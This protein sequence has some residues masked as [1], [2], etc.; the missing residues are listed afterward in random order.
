ME[1]IDY[2]VRLGLGVYSAD[3]S[4]S[5]DSMDQAI[6]L[7]PQVERV[8]PLEGKDSEIEPFQFESRQEL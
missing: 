4:H 1:M 8:A 2:L 6:H 5:E 3:Q 7:G